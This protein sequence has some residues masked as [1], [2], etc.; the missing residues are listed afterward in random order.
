MYV[1]YSFSI[2]IHTKDVHVQK[3]RKKRKM[4]EKENEKRIHV[5]SIRCTNTTCTS[6]LH[7]HHV[8]DKTKTARYIFIDD[9]KTI[10]CSMSALRARAARC[11]AIDIDCPP[12]I[13]HLSSIYYR[14]MPCHHHYYIRAII[15]TIITTFTYIHTYITNI[16]LAGSSRKDI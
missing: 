7:V 15:I 4:R 11:Q 16:V 10:K 6:F 14:D 8:L 13:Y 9:K 1:H 5:R 2:I 3:K 12:F